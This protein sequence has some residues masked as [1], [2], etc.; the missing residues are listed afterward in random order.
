MSGVPSIQR[1]LANDRN[2]VLA[3]T[4]TPS[5]VKP[6]ANAVLQLPQARAGSGAAILS[7]TYTG[8]DDATYDVEIVD[9]I[10]TS[11]IISKPVFRGAGN[12]EISG[13]AAT[14]LPSQTIT[15]TL[16]D[17]GTE[18]L[19][20]KV[21]FE[22][23]TLQARSTGVAGNS[24]SIN[25]SNAGL[26]FTDSAFSTIDDIKAGASTELKG[27][28]YDWDT[29]VLGGNR[30]I[31]SN[32]HRVAFGEDRNNIYLNWKE[33][34][35]DSW[36]YGF[37]PQIAADVPKGTR[38]KFVTG[39]RTVTVSD[40]TTTEIYPG[41]V[42]LYDFLSAVRSTSNL[43]EVMG[44]VTNDRAPGGQASREFKL[45]TDAYA[46]SNSGSS[47]FSPGGFDNVGIGSTAN[48]EIIQA[49]CIA[50]NAREN[51]AASV[52]AEIWA[53]SGSV[54]GDLGTIVSGQQYSEPSL[55]S[56]FALR[57][58]RKV[59]EGFDKPRGKFSVT[60][61]G[62]ASRA[63]NVEPPEIC[64][65][66]LALGPSAVDQSIT[67]VYTK[68]PAATCD[69]DNLPFPDLSNHLY[70]TGLEGDS[71]VSDITSRLGD[72]YEW[73]RNFYSS[74]HDGAAPFPPT[75]IGES[76]GVIDSDF[77][78]FIALLKSLSG[79]GTTNLENWDLLFADFK[80]YAEGSLSEG[81]QATSSGSN[82]YRISI[83]VTGFEINLPDKNISSLVIKDSS[84]TPQTLAL[85]TN[86]TQDLIYGKVTFTTLTGMVAPFN[87]TYSK[88]ATSFTRRT[89]VVTTQTTGQAYD[90]PG[91]NVSQF[92]AIRPSDNSVISASNYTINP[93]DGT[94]TWSTAPSTLGTSNWQARRIPLT[95][96]QDVG[97]TGQFNLL[98]LG[99]NNVAPTL[100]SFVIR[101]ENG[102]DVTN[103]FNTPS[104]VSGGGF[105]NL[106]VTTIDPQLITT[107]FGKTHYLDYDQ[108]V[109]G[110]SDKYLFY[111]YLTAGSSASTGTSGT[112][113]LNMTAYN[114][115]RSAWPAWKD[116]I[117]AKAGKF[118]ASTIQG[119]GSWRDFG[120]AFYWTVNGSVGGS[121]GHAFTNRPYFSARQNSDSVS[122]NATHEFAFQ[123]NVAPGCVAQLVA[124]DRITLSIGDSAWQP[125]YQVGDTM[126]L[127]IIAAQNLFLAGGQAG[128]NT[129]TW[130]VAGSVDGPFSNYSFDPDTPIA[131]NSG[132]LQFLLS[133]GSTPFAVDD[134]FRFAI[135]GGH[136]RYRKN[137]G[138][139]S[140]LSAISTATVALIDGLSI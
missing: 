31:P 30:A 134:Q 131:Y 82:A 58:P 74:L 65:R 68:R 40:G 83:A 71:I 80:Q 115:R 121:Y 48:T 140:A 35:R 110:G 44:A 41:I 78:S 111:E 54:S 124:G 86:Y 28:Q 75:T 59:P 90:L 34:K 125:T 10:A 42:T 95:L 138:A 62:Y 109:S 139:W 4:L 56:K 136:Y 108:P 120:D 81:F 112:D 63:G 37:T 105:V 98:K 94:I 118:E 117:L 13:I 88:G 50:A 73:R 11:P 129:Q 5:S 79:T 39:G 12:G 18:T 53:L 22:G 77:L 25:V 113:T 2:L 23:V 15:I 93:I 26:T 52:G 100:A 132:G 14:A 130:N 128:N 89:E 55:P 8:A 67:L 106:S 45:R 70:L 49:V 135:E 126:S 97:T 96:N 24:I 107:F 85:G 57:V 21:E 87:A 102:T 7:G 84:P 17:S 16:A 29:K 127:S 69:C 46:S 9:N 47:K 91:I 137:A 101:N 1:F 119:D 38:I 133:Q 6:I 116:D 3:S 76:S 114:D 20:A 99:A 66:S 64:V 123:I 19:A 51:P 122:Y 103:L 72:A 27:A 32:A 43:I 61:T 92:R 104:L 33:W 60:Q 36:A